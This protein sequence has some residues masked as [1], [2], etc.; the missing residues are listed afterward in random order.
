MFVVTAVWVSRSNAV[1]R[2]TSPLH[3]ITLVADRD[4]RETGRKEIGLKIT[5]EWEA[6]GHGSNLTRSFGEDEQFIRVR[7]ERK[8]RI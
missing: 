4:V 1:R 7:V 3:L 5:L 8:L 2:R 6:A